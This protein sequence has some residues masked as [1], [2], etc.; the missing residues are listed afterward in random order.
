MIFYKL[1]SSYNCSSYKTSMSKWIK[2][3]QK[4]KSKKDHTGRFQFNKD[5]SLDSQQK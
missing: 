2:G 5:P 4:I 3:D 1:E